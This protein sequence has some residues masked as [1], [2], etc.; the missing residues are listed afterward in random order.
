[1]GIEPRQKAELDAGLKALHTWLVN[2]PN[3]RDGDYWDTSGRLRKGV[4]DTQKLLRAE[5]IDWDKVDKDIHW[6]GVNFE[7]EGRSVLD[8]KASDRGM[9]RSF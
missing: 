8:D 1:M 3:Q 4:T 7:D 2:L 9:R 5:K 6:L